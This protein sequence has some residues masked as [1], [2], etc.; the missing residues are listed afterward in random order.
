MMELLDSMYATQGRLA[1]AKGVALRKTLALLS[2]DVDTFLIPRSWKECVTDIF[3]AERQNEKRRILAQAIQ[4]TDLALQATY[5]TLS[6]QNTEVAQ[7]LASRRLHDHP[8]VIF[9][10][11]RQ[12]ELHEESRQIEALAFEFHEFTSGLVA[13]HH[14]GDAEVRQI[15]QDLDRYLERTT[16][17]INTLHDRIHQHGC[18]DIIYVGQGHHLA[19]PRPLLVQ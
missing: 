15:K 7:N 12:R 11:N 8:I 2:L 16:A 10:I 14:R 9:K 6:L 13:D 1:A 5:L 19:Y 3:S 4:R 18:E 17:S